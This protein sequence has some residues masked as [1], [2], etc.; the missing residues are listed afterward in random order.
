MNNSIQAIF[1]QLK[2]LNQAELDFVNDFIESLL[3][4]GNYSFAELEEN[5]VMERFEEYM[6]DPSKSQ[7]FDE[8]LNKIESESD[9]LNVELP[10]WEKEVLDH[11]LNEYYQN[12]NEVLDFEKT[13]EAIEKNV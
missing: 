13:L 8:I 12:P 9:L 6:R 7:N 3:K 2:K 11:R 5:M 4:K 10:I 1:E